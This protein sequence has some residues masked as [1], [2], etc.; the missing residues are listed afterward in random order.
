MKQWKLLKISREAK[1]QIIKS[2]S[3]GENSWIILTTI[4]A[5]K[6]ETTKD[7]NLKR[8]KLR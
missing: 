8:Q 5:L 3:H 6:K 2:I 1:L 4:K 7:I